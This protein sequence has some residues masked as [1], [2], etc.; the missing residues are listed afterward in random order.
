VDSQGEE[1]GMKR[2]RNV[3]LDHC[4]GSAEEILT[5][6]ERACRDFTGATA[7]FDDITMLIAK[8]M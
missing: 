6:L 8:S 2:V 3:L 5:A 4:Q 7:P 1:F